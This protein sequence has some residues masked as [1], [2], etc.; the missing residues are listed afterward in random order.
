V[1]D[2]DLLVREPGAADVGAD[3]AATPE[4]QSFGGWLEELAALRASPDDARRADLVRRV[5]PRW[6][7]LL[8]LAD[9]DGVVTQ[10]T[11]AEDDRI[12]GAFGPYDVGAVLGEGGFSTVYRAR[13]RATGREVA[14]KVLSADGTLDAT[15]LR[16]FTDEGRLRVEHPRVVKVLDAGVEQQRPYVV[17]ELLAGGTLEALVTELRALPASDAQAW[18]A[19]LDA[20]GVAPGPR[21]G[22]Q[23]ERYARRIAG[24]FASVFQA[25]EVLAA[26][27]LVHRDVKPANLLFDGTGALKV[28]DF[29]LAHPAGRTT[30]TG[31]VQAL[32]SLPY[33]SPEQASGGSHDAGPAADVHALAVSLYEAL[34][35]APPF[36]GASVGEVL[37][38]IVHHAP[39][40]LAEQRPGVPAELAALLA[41]CLEKAPADRPTAGEVASALE[42]I[43]A[44]KPGSVA[45]LPLRRR[46]LRAA[47]GHRV[48]VAATLGAV[49]AVAGWWAFAESRDAELEVLAF[50]RAALALDGRAQGETP[51]TLTLDDG[52]HLVTLTAS[53]FRPHEDEATLRPGA[54]ERWRIALVPERPDDREAFARLAESLGHAAP[55]PATPPAPRAPLEQA[56]VIVSPR[57]RVAREGL[58]LAVHGP[59]RTGPAPTFRCYASSSPNVALFSGSVT[60]D[61]LLAGWR[62]PPGWSAKV[63]AAGRVRAEV[64]VPDG[65]PLLVSEFEVVDGPPAARLLAPLGP[66]PAVHPR[67]VAALD[68][69]SQGRA[70]EA[71]LDARRL[72]DEHGPNSLVVD[73]AL[74]ALDRLGLGSTSTY[75]DL[76]AQR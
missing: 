24:L 60:A 33:M 48:A 12:H 59:L 52:T 39:P 30:L 67:L 15:A 64:E 42:Q 10:A 57:G 34:A 45:A 75:A 35:L 62:L 66:D 38:A 70:A 68:V 9:L 28:G 56:A 20:R 3:E 21:G 1:S 58:T 54:R 65:G 5:G 71:Y 44:G 6:D 18:N 17:M 69:L 40:S 22:T 16:R 76:F 46:L 27:E 4:E 37:G 36:V 47:S 51:R 2:A 49:L 25:F 63:A 31:H 26:R 29:G 43:A 50:P 8:A 53:G 14:L 41:R 32:G 73:T 19:A 55:L 72:I 13:E 23:A 74:T 61:D 11:E 7:E